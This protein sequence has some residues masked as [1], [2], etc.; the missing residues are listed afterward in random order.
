MPAI[1]FQQLNDTFELRG[2]EIIV[3]SAT[4]AADPVPDQSES[5]R[6]S[7]G[8]LFGGIANPEGCMIGV[9]SLA[10]SEFRSTMID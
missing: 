8:N 10:P 2:L 3:F 5:G 9:L 6:L 1:A 7:P 4:V